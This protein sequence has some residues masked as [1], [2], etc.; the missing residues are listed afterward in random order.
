MWALTFHIPG[1]LEIWSWLMSCILSVRDCC[2]IYAGVFDLLNWLICS[3][4]PERCLILWSRSCSNLKHQS[5]P[6]C[7]ASFHKLFYNLKN[8]VW[9]ADFVQLE[10]HW[11]C[12][13]NLKIDYLVVLNVWNTGICWPGL[14]CKFQPEGEWLYLFP[15]PFR[16]SQGKNPESKTL[17]VL[18]DHWKS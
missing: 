14:N 6:S 17:E 2:W 7:I 12:Q 8:G 3:I 9:G 5:L 16:F 1:M 15:E 10:P 18:W 11:H 4:I 13:T